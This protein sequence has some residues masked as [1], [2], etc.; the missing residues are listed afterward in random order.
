MP[1]PR[2]YPSRPHFPGPFP[3]V[4]PLLDHLVIIQGVA[5]ILFVGYV[6]VLGRPTLLSSPVDASLGEIVIVV[7]MRGVNQASSV[8]CVRAEVVGGFAAVRVMVPEP[9]IPTFLGVV[10]GSGAGVDRGYY[11]TRLWPSYRVSVRFDSFYNV[12]YAGVSPPP[13]GQCRLVC[14]RVELSLSRLRG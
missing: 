10:A 4:A 5:K 11:A 6:V 14:G 12:I 13:L 1:Q 3:N 8:V 9:A 7:T 2:T